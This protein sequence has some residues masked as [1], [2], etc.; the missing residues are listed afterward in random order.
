MGDI[1]NTIG[2]VIIPLLA[3]IISVSL[4]KRNISN[5]VVEFFSQGNT[6]EQSAQGTVLCVRQFQQ[7][8]PNIHTKSRWGIHTPPADFFLKNYKNLVTN[9]SFYTIKIVN[10]KK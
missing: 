9:I 6:A 8:K 3:L 10:N 7:L 2:D 4:Y 1:L 5:T